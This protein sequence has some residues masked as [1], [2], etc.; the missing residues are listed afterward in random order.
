MRS[1]QAVYGIIVRHVTQDDVI[2]FDVQR[3]SHVGPLDLG[4]IGVRP[5]E[6]CEAH[7]AKSPVRRRTGLL[8]LTSTIP[9]P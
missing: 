7:F 8:I 3:S 9:A 6:K 4:R 2:S 5:A 1:L